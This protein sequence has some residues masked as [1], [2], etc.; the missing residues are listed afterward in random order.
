MDDEQLAFLE[1]ELKKA[2]AVGRPVAIFT[3]APIMG[4]GLKVRVC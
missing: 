2:E 1:A 3:H 4:S